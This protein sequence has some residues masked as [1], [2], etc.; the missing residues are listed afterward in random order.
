MGPD[1]IFPEGVLG[2]STS[3]P[4]TPTIYY[5]KGSSTLSE[6]HSAA[7]I[8]KDPIIDPEGVMGDPLP[9]PTDRGHSY[10]CL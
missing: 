3:L 7:R 1:N 4:V 2:G 9:S 10:I 6:T 8:Y 5:T